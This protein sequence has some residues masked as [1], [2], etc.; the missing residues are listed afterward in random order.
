MDVSFT[1]AELATRLDHDPGD[2]RHRAALAAVASMKRDHCPSIL[3]FIA[4]SL[5]AQ[6]RMDAPALR[7]LRILSTFSAEEN[8]KNTT[9]TI[10]FASA[11]RI[12]RALFEILG[13]YGMLAPI[14]AAAYLSADNAFHITFWNGNPWAA[15]IQ[16]VLSVLAEHC[17]RA[18]LE[19]LLEAWPSEVSPDELVAARAQEGPPPGQPGQPGQRRGKEDA[20]LLLAT[21]DH[22]STNPINMSAHERVPD[23]AMLPHPFLLSVASIAVAFMAPCK[24]YVKANTLLLR[25]ATLSLVF[26]QKNTSRCLLSATFLMCARNISRYAEGLHAAPDPPPAPDAGAP[27]APDAGVEPS[28][29][30]SAWLQSNARA[31]D[32]RDSADSEAFLHHAVSG[33]GATFLL[34]AVGHIVRSITADKSTLL[35]TRILQL[36]VLTRL[37]LSIPLGVLAPL[38]PSVF[39]TLLAVVRQVDNYETATELLAEET[40]HF[41]AYPVLAHVLH[42]A[43]CGVTGVRTVA[44]PS[45]PSVVQLGAEGDWADAVTRRAFRARPVNY[46]TCDFQ[47]LMACVGTFVTRFLAVVYKPAESPAVSVSVSSSFQ[48]ARAG[49]TSFLDSQSGPPGPPGQ[50]HQTGQSVMDRM[51]STL[52]VNHSSESTEPQSTGQLQFATGQVVTVQPHDVKTLIAHLLHLVVGIT[53]VIVTY[54]A[55]CRGSLAHSA[56]RVLKAHA[57]AVEAIIAGNPDFRQTP[58]LFFKEY[59]YFVHLT[60]ALSCLFIEARPLLAPLLERAAESPNISSKLACLFLACNMLSNIFDDEDFHEAFARDAAAIQSVDTL[61]AERVLAAVLPFKVLPLGRCTPDHVDEFHS[62]CLNIIEKFNT[63]GT[64]REG[65]EQP[66]PQGQKSGVRTFAA[67]FSYSDLRRSDKRDLALKA[68]IEHYVLRLVHTLLSHGLLWRQALAD[69]VCILLHIATGSFVPHPEPLAANTVAA[70]ARRMLSGLLAQRTGAPTMLRITVTAA[71]LEFLSTRLPPFDDS[72]KA[73]QPPYAANALRA[74]AVILDALNEALDTLASSDALVAYVFGNRSLGILLATA[75][76]LLAVKSRRYFATVCRFFH[77]LAAMFAA[78]AGAGAG[79]EGGAAVAAAAAGPPVFAMAPGIAFNLQSRILRASE[80]LPADDDAG[81]IAVYSCFDSFAR[82]PPRAVH[83]PRTFCALL[84]YH[85]AALERLLSVRAALP[86]DDCAGVA[87]RDAGLSFAAMFPGLR[88]RSLS[89]AAE[90]ENNLRARVLLADDPDYVVEAFFLDLVFFLSKTTVSDAAVVLSNSFNAAYAAER[91]IKTALFCLHALALVKKYES[92]LVDPDFLFGAKPIANT[93]LGVEVSYMS[94]TITRL[95]LL[96]ENRKQSRAIP[97]GIFNYFLSALSAVSSYMA[98]FCIARVQ[99]PQTRNTTCASI[100]MKQLTSGINMLEF[101]VPISSSNRAMRDAASR[102]NLVM[103]STSVQ[104]YVLEILYAQLLWFAASGYYLTFMDTLGTAVRGLSNDLFVRSMDADKLFTVLSNMLSLA[105][106]YGGFPRV[107]ARDSGQRSLVVVGTG[108]INRNLNSAKFEDIMAS[109]SLSTVI[110][111]FEKNPTLTPSSS[112]YPELGCTAGVLE[113]VSHRVRA[114]E[115]VSA[116][117]SPSANAS[118]GCGGSSSG[119]SGD[120][121]TG[122]SVD[123]AEDAGN[124]DGLAEGAGDA[125]ATILTAKALP[126]L[127]APTMSQDDEQ[128]FFA[129]R[130]DQDTGLSN[131]TLYMSQPDIS[132]AAK[133]AAGLLRPSSVTGITSGRASMADMSLDLA[134]PRRETI[135][136]LAADAQQPLPR[137]RTANESSTPDLHGGQS[138]TTDYQQSTTDPETSTS[139]MDMGVT[140]F[141][142][143]S[144]DTIISLLKYNQWTPDMRTLILQKV[145]SII[146]LYSDNQADNDAYNEYIHARLILLLVGLFES[147]SHVYTL[148][149][150]L[151]FLAQYAEE[152]NALVRARISSVVS[153][154]LSIVSRIAISSAAGRFALEASGYAGVCTASYVSSIPAKYR[155]SGPLGRL[156][157]FVHRFISTFLLNGCT[158]AVVEILRCLYVFEFIYAYVAGATALQKQLTRGPGS[159][160]SSSEEQ[161]TGPC[162]SFG[163]IGPYKDLDDVLAGLPRDGPDINVYVAVAGIAVTE[164]FAI[165]ELQT[166]QLIPQ[167]ICTCI[168]SRANFLQAILSLVFMHLCNKQLHMV[169]AEQSDGRDADN[170]GTPSLQDHGSLADPD[171]IEGPPE[172]VSEC[173]GMRPEQLQ[174]LIDKIVWDS[175]AAGEKRL[176]AVLFAVLAALSVPLS[177]RAEAFVSFLYERKNRNKMLIPSYFHDS[178]TYYLRPFMYVLSGEFPAKDTSGFAFSIPQRLSELIR[179]AVSKLSAECFRHIQSK[180]IACVRQLV[181]S[182]ATAD[183][184]LCINNTKEMMVLLLQTAFSARQSELYTDLTSESSSQYGNLLVGSICL[185]LWALANCVAVQIPQAEVADIAL[186]YRT[187]LS[188]R[189]ND[190][191][192]SA[193]KAVRK[194]LQFL[195]DERENVLGVWKDG[196]HNAFSVVA[197]TLSNVTTAMCDAHGADRCSEYFQH[198]LGVFVQECPPLDS[199][200]D[201]LGLLHLTVYK[202]VAVAVNEKTD[203][204]AAAPQATRLHEILRD[205]LQSALRVPPAPSYVFDRNKPCRCTS[206]AYAPVYIYEIVSYFTHASANID[207]AVDQAP[208][209]DTVSLT[210]LAIEAVMRC[211]T[212]LYDNEIKQAC[213]SY[214][215]TRVTEKRY[216]EAQ[217]SALL[218]EIILDDLNCVDGIEGNIT[219]AVFLLNSFCQQMLTSG[220]YRNQLVAFVSKQIVPIAFLANS[221]SKSVRKGVRSLLGSLVRVIGLELD[222]EK[223][224]VQGWDKRNTMVKAICLKYYKHTGDAQAIFDVCNSFLLVKKASESICLSALS[225]LTAFVQERHLDARKV[226]DVLTETLHR[227]RDNKVESE[228]LSYMRVLFEDNVMETMS[229]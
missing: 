29:A 163:F 138:T 89:P 102:I 152:S 64:A 173:A 191:D 185:L 8:S 87:R 193:L 176:P 192:S 18:V 179:P 71:L 90:V 49:L 44:S 105:L 182:G 27:G 52:T 35:F 127:F 51:S 132:S 82:Q 154:W 26:V 9:E 39:Y 142:V 166:M 61:F 59:Y 103:P 72:G 10:P 45:S 40:R 84:R 189:V 24:Y 143:V 164:L 107:V 65:L 229:V 172:D 217:L 73:D 214:L 66:G 212:R 99:N 110:A 222:I 23:A 219:L 147:E 68:S 195:V 111:Y 167:F 146:P 15:S 123:N 181:S 62:N 139:M 75:F 155:Y 220:C 174:S 210:D 207:C 34:A 201:V 106:L 180:F 16:A 80:I 131:S 25:M 32:E 56:P 2:G 31:A 136:G 188:L 57:A 22:Q 86:D 178:A 88:W 92:F 161:H 47:D 228:T 77:H 13:E 171:S 205:S 69:C 7:A 38:L 96:M 109:D 144:L 113:L 197:D 170:A 125:G 119:S 156:R 213:Y 4:S 134:R 78:G 54:Y 165:N 128:R 1:L 12:T 215:G 118:A 91:S 60:H 162:A 216:T 169:A 21:L 151:Q 199:R 94:E 223:F 227:N 184:I 58:R 50:A 209:A 206:K 114:R 74:C 3:E 218:E 108:S 30:L 122:G 190:E 226:A 168:G 194:Q 41:L 203:H 200:V 150:T 95:Y 11:Y 85:T 160:S 159:G 141:H 70:E 183:L 135:S 101:V 153:H 115:G 46:I 93:D 42:V 79:A 43:S 175:V 158:E 187:I 53:P 100:L 5:E 204:S 33:P 116:R 19:A 83:L 130:T 48:D 124:V 63:P 67:S 98:L 225:V 133:K 221:E 121:G 196:A 208:E 177:T 157:P 149:E 148:V 28:D 36:Q 211:K 76:S 224:E 17:W 120:G 198:S 14:P 145:L 129:S 37:L 97:A 112:L 140:Y 81:D 117:G 6:K 55:P 186:L 104:K 126:G 137:G 202:A 20:T